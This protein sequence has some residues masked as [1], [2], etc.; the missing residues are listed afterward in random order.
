MHTS[1]SVLSCQFQGAVTD[2]CSL[3]NEKQ[4][5]T[6]AQVVFSPMGFHLTGSEHG[7][8]GLGA[9]KRVH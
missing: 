3:K 1:T 8:A 5:V 2:V 9:G 6:P 4:R 7:G